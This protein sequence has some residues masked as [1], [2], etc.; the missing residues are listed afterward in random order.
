MHV[1]KSAVLSNSLI[2]GFN[3]LTSQSKSLTTVDFSA[4][5]LHGC[6]LLL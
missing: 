6:Q 2:C 5:S 3:N 1:S 4:I